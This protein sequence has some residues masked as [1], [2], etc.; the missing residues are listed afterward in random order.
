MVRRR[1]AL[2]MAKMQQAVMTFFPEGTRISQ[3]RGGFVLWVE[4][5]ASLDGTALMR[6][7]IEHHISITPGALFAINGAFR[8]CIRLNAAVHWSAQVEAAIAFLGHAVRDPIFH[9]SADKR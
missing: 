3:P 9:R 6:H 2:A 7:A 4:L 8:H 1:H 5:A